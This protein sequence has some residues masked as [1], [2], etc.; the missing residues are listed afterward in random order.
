[1]S[2][3]RRRCGPLVVGALLLLAAAGCPDAGPPVPGAGSAAVSPTAGATTPDAPPAR[4]VSLAPNVTETIFALGRGDRIVGATRYCDY[5]A[6][7][8]ELPRVGDYSN[9]SLEL[10]V[11]AEPDLVVTPAEGLTRPLIEKLEQLGIAVHVFRAKDVDT[12]VAAIRALGVAIGAP[13]EGDRVAD[14]LEA[15]SAEVARLAANARGAGN[16]PPR[17]LFCIDRSPLVLAGAGSLG[18][19]LLRRCGA[20]NVAAKLET[21]YPRPPL[22]TVL[23]LAPDVIIDAVMVPGGDPHELAVEFWRTQAPTIP[24]VKSG[25]VYGLVPDR[26]VRAGPRLAGGLRELARAVHGIGE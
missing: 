6:E 15:A 19:D 24:A 26:V 4:I 1:M 13:E 9:P 14:D 22:E 5:P 16:A 10:V 11:A 12:T 17:V 8:K 2:A 3:L 7:A 21:A 18:D 20:E 23:T 25:R